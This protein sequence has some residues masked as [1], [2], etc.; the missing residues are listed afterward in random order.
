MGVTA[1]GYPWIEDPD[2]PADMLAWTADAAGA[3]QT[4]LDT[5]EAAPDPHGVY[6]RKAGGT[7]TGPLD[8]AGDAESGLQAVPKRQLD[9]RL[10]Q[11]MRSYVRGSAASNGPG[12]PVPVT[13]PLSIPD[14]PAGT[15]LT[16][17]TV[18]CKNASTTDTYGL[19]TFFLTGSKSQQWI[20]EADSRYWRT[21]SLQTVAWHPGGPLEL[22]WGVSFSG[23]AGVMVGH[24]SS[25]WVVRVSD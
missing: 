14:A 19:F 15:Y 5:H 12:A 23:G 17:A 13:Q 22:E 24:E 18:V 3:A 6:L 1:D 8:L 2:Q 10:A 4:V 16:G 9:A 20:E 11:V 25:A 21:I 7:M